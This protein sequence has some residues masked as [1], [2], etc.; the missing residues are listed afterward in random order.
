MPRICWP[1]EEFSADLELWQVFT[2]AILVFRALIEKGKTKEAKQYLLEAGNSPGS[3]QMEV[4]AKIELWHATTEKRRAKKKR[5]INFDL[6]KILENGQTIGLTK[7]T[8][9]RKG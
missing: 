6:P 2:T 7:S 3:P 9:G 1:C 4:S 8:K 5:F